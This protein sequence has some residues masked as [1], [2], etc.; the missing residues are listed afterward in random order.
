MCNF[1]RQLS[2][3][4]ALFAIFTVI[5]TMIAVI[6]LWVWQARKIGG[7]VVRHSITDRVWLVFHSETITGTSKQVTETAWPKFIWCTTLILSQR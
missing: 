7:A 3:L 2:L 5:F 4:P 1:V 6:A